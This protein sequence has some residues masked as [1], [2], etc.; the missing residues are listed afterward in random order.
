MPILD[1]ADE[2]VPLPMQLV[3]D[4]SLLL[5]CRKGD[6]NPFSQAA[7]KFIRRLGES[8]AQ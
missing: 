6:D 1:L 5:A 7:R 2:A 3:L 4:M 8:I